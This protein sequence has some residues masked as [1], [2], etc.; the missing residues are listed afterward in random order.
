MKADFNDE[1]AL[2]L[3]PQNETERLALSAWHYA[4]VTGDEVAGTAGEVEIGKVVP[5]INTALKPGI[6]WDPPRPSFFGPDV[7][8]GSA[9]ARGLSDVKC[10]GVGE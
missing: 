10:E 8:C 9:D 5:D 2:V 1:G 6:Q 4:R 3:T 7:T